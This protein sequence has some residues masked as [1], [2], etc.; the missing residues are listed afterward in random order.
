MVTFSQLNLAEDHFPSVVSMTNAMDV[1]FCRN[2]LMYFTPETVE[3]VIEYFHR[4]LLDDGWLVTGAVES[5]A[6]TFRSFVVLP[7]HD[8]PIYRKASMAR[9]AP[10]SVVELSAVPL[11]LPPDVAPETRIDLDVVHRLYAQGQ[12]ADVVDRSRALLDSGGEDGRLMTVMARALANL[13]RLEEA[14]EWCRKAVALDR[15]DPR[16]RYLLGM[17]HR[18]RGEPADAIAC[19]NGVLFLDAANIL[20][21]FSLAELMDRLGRRS[22]A[23]R[24]YENALDFLTALPENEELPD[25]D[26]M[27]AGRLSDII[28]S[29]V[30]SSEARR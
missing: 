9:P 15:V 4:A 28:R 18:E 1:I 23:R 6:T 8:L 17:I 30:G 22:D 21:H 13:G 26:G 11:P 10:L 25:A 12:Y 27:T 20:A 19:F 7:P 16:Q 5:S 29:A 3:R 24:H 2:V 14:L